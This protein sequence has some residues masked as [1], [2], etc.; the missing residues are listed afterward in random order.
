M[1]SRLLDLATAMCEE[2]ERWERL[3]SGLGMW[4]SL[5]SPGSHPSVEGKKIYRYI[6]HVDIFI[7]IDYMYVYVLKWFKRTF[8]FLSKSTFC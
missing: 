6:L 7:Y 5:L 3:G 2:G 1:S 8:L 4:L